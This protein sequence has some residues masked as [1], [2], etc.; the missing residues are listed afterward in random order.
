[1]TDGEFQDEEDVIRVSAAAR[2][3]GIIIYVIG[4]GERSP[5]LNLATNDTSHVYHQDDFHQLLNF[6]NEMKIVQFDCF[7]PSEYTDFCFQGRKKIS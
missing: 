6:I 5:K 1:M 7:K 2:K 4:I 3:I